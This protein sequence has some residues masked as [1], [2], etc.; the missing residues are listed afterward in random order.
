MLPRPTRLRFSLR[1]LF[2]VMTAFAIVF[3]IVAA[4]V[5][6]SLDPAGIRETIE[7]HGGT[8][9]VDGIRRCA[10]NWVQTLLGTEYD[11]NIVCVHF[12]DAEVSDDALLC[13]RRLPFLKTICVQDCSISDD[14][15][16]HLRRLDSARDLYFINTDIGDTGVAR[17]K[18]M[19]S[20]D[21]LGLARTKITDKSMEHVTHMPALR[22]LDVRRTGVTDVGLRHL[23]KVRGLDVLLITDTKVTDDGIMR[24]KESLPALQV[25]AKPGDGFTVSESE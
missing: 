20:L 12:F 21:I 4:K 9:D 3:A 22:I 18:G 25:V 17:L 15:V 14:T 7:R 16:S 5:R 23:E 2:V 11:G 24:L 19:E 8:V 1:S 13:L 6:K 10:P